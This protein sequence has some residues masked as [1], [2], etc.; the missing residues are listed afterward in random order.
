MEV[1]EVMDETGQG[2]PAP[3]T[4]IKFASDEWIKAVMDAVNQSEAY[5]EAARSWEG[6]FNFV[7]KFPNGA[8]DAVLYMDLW[9]G[10]C[11]AA[12]RVDGAQ[13]RAPEFLVVGPLATWRKVLER[14]LDPIMSLVT[15]QLILSGQLLKVMRVPRATLELVHCCT[16]VPTEWP[17]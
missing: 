17:E 1:A 11:R 8:P 7:V 3:R 12:C 4:P 14:K 6:D 13:E 5:R 10:A 9:H 15:R 16:L 2:G